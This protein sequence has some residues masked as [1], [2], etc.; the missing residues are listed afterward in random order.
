MKQIKK[1]F[2]AVFSEKYRKI[3]ELFDAHEKSVSNMIEKKCL[4]KGWIIFHKKSKQILIQSNSGRIK[5][6]KLNRVKDLVKEKLNT[7]KSQLS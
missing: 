6:A 5:L 3:S 2:T 7:L 1:N 4:M